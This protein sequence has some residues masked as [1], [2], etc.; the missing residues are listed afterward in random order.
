MLE[1]NT[2]YGKLQPEGLKLDRAY[3][4]GN[5]EVESTCNCRQCHSSIYNIRVASGSPELTQKNDVQAIRQVML[6]SVNISER[7]IWYQLQKKQY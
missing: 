3:G 6:P 7:C 1:A 4:K 2:N 5:K